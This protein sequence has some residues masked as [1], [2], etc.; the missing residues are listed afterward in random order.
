MSDKVSIQERQRR[1]S[2]GL[3]LS[4]ERKRKD[5]NDMSD[6]I[7]SPKHY[8]HGAIEPIDVIEDWKF[9]FNL[10]NVIKYLARS[11]HKGSRLQDLQKA[12]WYLQREIQKAMLTENKK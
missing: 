11:N 9:G 2:E 5:V 7:S 10:G 8:T 4:W 6:P 3:K 12:E 1:I